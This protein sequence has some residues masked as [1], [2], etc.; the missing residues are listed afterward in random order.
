M[1]IKNQIEQPL[2][3]YTPVGWKYK[4]RFLFS[5]FFIILQLKLKVLYE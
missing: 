5:M 1:S 2:I 4:R 3:I